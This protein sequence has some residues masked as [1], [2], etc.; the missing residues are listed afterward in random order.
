MTLSLPQD[1][2]EL[3]ADR[4]DD[5]SLSSCSFLFHLSNQYINKRKY[6]LFLSF[7][8]TPEKTFHFNDVLYRKDIP[9]LKKVYSPTTYILNISLMMDVELLGPFHSSE[10]HIYFLRKRNY[11]LEEIAGFISVE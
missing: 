10:E 9:Q 8:V 6:D 1:I 7:C 11:S 3:I 5:K 2:Q 4:L